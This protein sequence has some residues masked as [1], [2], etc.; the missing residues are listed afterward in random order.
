MSLEELQRYSWGGTAPVPRGPFD[1]APALPATA[2][3]RRHSTTR[4]STRKACGRR[5]RPCSERRCEWRAALLQP[6]ATTTATLSPAQRRDPCKK[7]QPWSNL[8]SPDWLLAGSSLAGRSVR[9]CVVVAQHHE[10]RG[11][12]AA[13]SRARGGPPRGRRRCE[14]AVRQARGVDT[15]AAS[16]SGTRSR[17]VSIVWGAGSS[18]PA[19]T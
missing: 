19:Q 14:P 8:P 17:R 10:Q 4:A 15:R 1:P 18:V 2:D 7:K 6:S 12:P 5:R 13:R 3:T 9:H 11:A 16:R